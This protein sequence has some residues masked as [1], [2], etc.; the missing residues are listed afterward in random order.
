MTKSEN[1]AMYRGSKQTVEEPKAPVE[2]GDTEAEAGDSEGG[3]AVEVGPSLKEECAALFA[4]LDT[5]ENNE[6]SYSEVLRWTK[7]DTI[8]PPLKG[9]SPMKVCKILNKDGDAKVTLEEF[10]AACLELLGSED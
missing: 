6:L 1:F 10:E 4:S 2:E 5:N 7:S 8:W 3:E 9:K